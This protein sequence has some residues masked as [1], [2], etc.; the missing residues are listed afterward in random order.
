MKPAFYIKLYIH[1]HVYIHCTPN[2]VILY[3]YPS[4]N[5]VCALQCIYLDLIDR[6]H[7]HPLKH[8]GQISEI[9]GVVGLGWSREQLSGD[10]V[11][12]DC[13]G[14]NQLGNLKE[15]Q[16]LSLTR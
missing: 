11:V 6:H 2:T 8:F 10:G 5:S 13:S 4:S 3:S 16:F 12:H 7:Q 15:E 9:E 14:A 1:V